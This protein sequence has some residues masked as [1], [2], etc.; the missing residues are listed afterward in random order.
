MAEAK[1]VIFDNEAVEALAVQFKA[2]GDVVT[3]RDICRE[4][5]NLMD[6]IIRG[7]KFD[8]QVPFDDIKNSLFLQMENW[9]MKWIPENGK[10]Y[11]YFSACIR[12]GCLSVVAKE[13][14]FNQRFSVTDIPL[15]VLIDQEARTSS[16]ISSGLVE[17]LRQAAKDIYCR[18]SEPVVQEVLRYMV[19]CVLRGRGDRRPHILKTVGLGWPI[20]L[21]TARFLLDWS[22]GAVRMA[23]LEHFH[24]PMGEIDMFRAA[25][26]FSLIPDII[27]AIGIEPTKKLMHIFAGTTV[28]FPSVQQVRKSRES[29]VVYEA[30]LANPTPETLKALGRKFRKSPAKIQEMYERV[31]VNVGSGVLEDTELFENSTPLADL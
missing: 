25:Q 10:L 16:E 6:A 13:A 14:L 23:L 1:K 26:R 12:N 5:G 19:S 28:R 9:V 15:D 22:H 30:M 8:R 7:N 31:S 29:M 18:W 2:T 17:V 27:D 24:Q 20:S 11:T 3:Y 4:S 21:E